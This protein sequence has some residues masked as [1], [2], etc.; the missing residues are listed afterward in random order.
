MGIDSGPAMGVV[1]GS[2]IPS[3]CIMSPRGLQQLLYQNYGFDHGDDDDDDIYIMMECICRGVCHE[4]VT[5][6]WIVD[7]DDIYN[8]GVYLSIVY[9]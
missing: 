4:K 6:S 9:V 1:A 8:G 5:P 7:D 3:Y 2:T